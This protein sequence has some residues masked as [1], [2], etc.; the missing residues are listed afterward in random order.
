VTELIVKLGYDP[1]FGAR[2][3][4]R[5]IRDKIREPLSE[6]IISGEI[7]RGSRVEVDAVGEE[8]KIETIA[9]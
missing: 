6:K 5:T 9:S 1:S 4:G 8:I 7:K 2:P 3:I